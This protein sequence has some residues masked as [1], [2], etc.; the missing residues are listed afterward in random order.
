MSCWKLNCI[1][2]MCVL[3]FVVYKLARS[4]KRN[5]TFWA[6]SNWTG[7]RA[8][9]PCRRWLRA[10]QGAACSPQRLVAGSLRSFPKDSRSCNSFIRESEW[11]EESGT[12]AALRGALA[13]KD[14]WPLVGGDSPYPA[15]K[16]R[17]C[18]L[19]LE[20]K[21][22]PARARMRAPIAAIGRREG[23]APLGSVLLVSFV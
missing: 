7:R 15:Q 23:P 11:L 10:P 14:G 6:A 17:T 9:Q 8:R 2:H 1:N 20:A 3:Y 21:T 18:K 4:Y 12:R 13:R 22:H 5:I 16:T 19:R